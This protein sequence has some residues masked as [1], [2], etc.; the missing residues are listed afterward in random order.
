MSGEQPT[1]VDIRPWSEGD[2]P[3][4]ERLMG[5]PTMTEHLGGVE[6]PEKIRQRHERYWRNN[7][8]E[9]GS[10]FVIVVGPERIAADSIGYWEKEWRG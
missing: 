9:K 5:D 6:A 4:L 2:L 8:S 7:D 1:N 3:L 10:M